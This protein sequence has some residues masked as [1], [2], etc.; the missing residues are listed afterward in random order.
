MYD[1]IADH[2]TTETTNAATAPI[3][4]WR[5][6]ETVLLGMREGNRFVLARGW[7]R[8][9]RLTDVRRWSFSDPARF[10]LQVRRLVAESG[11]TADD[12]AAAGIH[13]GAWTESAA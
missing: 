2:E 9:D 13:A 3:F 12:A 8:A 11:C 5:G 6:R 4:A 7:I 10:A 1:F